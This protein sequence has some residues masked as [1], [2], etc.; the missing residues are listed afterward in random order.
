MVF[1]EFIFVI[2]IGAVVAFTGAL[3]PEKQ[4]PNEIA[5]TP[6]TQ[7]AAANQVEG[8]LGKLML[9]VEKYRQSRS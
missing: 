1:V 4:D 7:V 5:K 2:V 6:E 3:N 9:V 8:A